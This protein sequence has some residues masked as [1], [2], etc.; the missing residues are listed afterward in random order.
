V[1]T[2]QDWIEMVAAPQERRAA[3]DDRSRADARAAVRHDHVTREEAVCGHLAERVLAR[4]LC[5]QDVDV[6]RH[7]GVDLLPDL[8][9]EGIPVAVRARR[10]SAM[11][12]VYAFTRQLRHEEERFFCG[13]VGERIVLLG[14]IS[15]VEFLMRAEL[16]ERGHV[17]RPGFT[18]AEAMLVLGIGDLEAPDVWLARVCARA[19]LA[20]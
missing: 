5:D 14:G 4:W 1:S 20:A 19:T 8:R 7:G 12:F 10:M 6:S 15:S 9:V 17:V 18:A 2:P 11:H 13:Y 16:H 3:Q